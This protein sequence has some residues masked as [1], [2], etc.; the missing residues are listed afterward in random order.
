MMKPVFIV[1]FVVCFS[2]FLQ[3][4]QDSVYRFLSVADS[5]AVDTT[6]EKLEG[7]AA[8][9]RFI[10]QVREKIRFEL[11][12]TLPE[13]FKKQATQEVMLGHAAQ[14]EQLAIIIDKSLEIDSSENNPNRRLRGP[15]KFDSRI[16]IRDLNPLKEEEREILTSARSVGMV[17]ERAWLTAVTDSIY[18]LD[19]SRSLGK[20]Y[21]LCPK[22]AY[23]DQ[24]VMGCG[25]AFIT[26]SMLMVSAGH[27]FSEPLDHYAVIF[28]FE[29][30]NER[31]A[32]PVFVSLKD[33]FYPKRIV[34][35][36]DNDVAVFETDRP[37]ERPA[38]KWTRSDSLRAGARV[39]MIGHPCGLPKKV[40][41]NASIA[42]ESSP[43]FF[44]T[45]LDAFQGNSGSP[46]FHFETHQVIGILVSGE[47]DFTWK[48]NCNAST[49]CQ[50]PFCEG[51]KVIRIENILE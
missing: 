51:E 2:E 22:E 11:S 13:D 14:L 26:D 16:E 23:F 21:N 50:I 10:N 44:H 4:Q 33:I 19:A 6:K 8:K 18:Q 35:Q 34:R 47:V 17:V 1:L 48:G 36:S 5:I 45:T 32:Y 39:Y 49:L 27:V 42:G 3:A 29:L 12:P 30:L 28:G 9:K 38:L 31:G 41:L 25:T 40:A 43:D 37:L 20:F 7:E 24:P 46:V 15:T